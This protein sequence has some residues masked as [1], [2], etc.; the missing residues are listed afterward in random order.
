MIEGINP[1]TDRRWLIDAA[2]IGQGKTGRI[3]ASSA[4][5]LAVASALD[6][7]GCAA[8]A[9]GYDVKPTSRHRFR[10]RTKLEANVVQACVVTVEPVPAKLEEA[11]ESEFVPDGEAALSVPDV[12]LDV[13][14]APVIETYANGRID[15]GQIAF[16]LLSVSLDPYPK[17]DGAELPGAAGGGA[18]SLSPFAA[19]AKLRKD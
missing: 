7:V 6:L 9:I 18:Q 8:L 13:L 16:E 5:C 10:L 17:K 4:E 11:A 2:T 15:L 3:E 1:L 14:N 12:P 19:L